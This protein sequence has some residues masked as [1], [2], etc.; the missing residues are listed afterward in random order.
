VIMLIL[1]LVLN[2]A[3]VRSVEMRS[4]NRQR[5]NLVFSHIL[6]FDKVLTP[7]QVARAERIFEKD[8][9]LRWIGQEILGYA[10][11]GVGLEKCNTMHDYLERLTK[12]F[13]DENYL[14]FVELAPNS[15]TVKIVLKNGCT[16]TDQL[17]AWLQA[18]IVTK[19]IYDSKTDKAVD[20]VSEIT[21]SLHRANKV[22]VE[23]RA[24]LGSA[25]W[26]FSE[27]ALE[28]NCGPRISVSNRN[29]LT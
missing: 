29:A 25:G 7:K 11:I 19:S 6:A 8:G 24:R 9:A 2:Y 26:T 13:R 14:L 1:H 16:P 23:H 10:R 15:T 28:T 21:T 18:M 22:F 27:A 17:K 20:L 5:A 12:V 4:L 3:A